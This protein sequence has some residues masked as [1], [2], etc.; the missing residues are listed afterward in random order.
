MPELKEQLG[1]QEVKDNLS[2]KDEN[3]KDDEKVHGGKEDQHDDILKREDLLKQGGG[4][5]G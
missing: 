3:H 2:K 1:A 5:K 4:D